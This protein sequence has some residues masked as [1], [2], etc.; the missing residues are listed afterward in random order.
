VKYTSDPSMEKSSF[1]K[2][3][4]LR[5]VHVLQHIKMNISVKKKAVKFVVRELPK[6][7]VVPYF[8]FVSIL[9]LQNLMTNHFV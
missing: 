9:L 1:F 4:L 2:M 8:D 7:P 3:K 6:P 5:D